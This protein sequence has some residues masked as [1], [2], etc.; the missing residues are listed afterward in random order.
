MA[1][2]VIFCHVDRKSD[3]RERSAFSGIAH[4][5]KAIAPQKAIAPEKSDRPL[6]GH[7]NRVSFVVPQ[8]T[9]IFTTETRFLFLGK[10]RDRFPG[11]VC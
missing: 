7:R 8:L 1:I 3:S 5:K 4:H 11:R 2:F 10:R 9:L 6:R